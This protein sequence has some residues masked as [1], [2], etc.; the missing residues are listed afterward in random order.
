MTDARQ[1]LEAAELLEAP[2]A[3]A[4]NAI[5]AAIAAADAITGKALRI[6]LS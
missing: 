3:V 6:R 5:H 2:D 4:N 1:L